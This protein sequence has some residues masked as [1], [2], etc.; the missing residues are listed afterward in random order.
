MKVIRKV[1]EFEWDKGNIDKNWL[2][3]NVTD[4]EAEEV[5]IDKRK[6]I[7]RDKIHSGKEERF[8]ILGKTKAGRLLFIVFTIRKHK[9]RVI[10]AR[11]INRKEVFLYEKKAGSTKI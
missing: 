3:H 8:R 7:F 1:L 2:K 4:K 10:S 5:F 6:F 11:D 9:V